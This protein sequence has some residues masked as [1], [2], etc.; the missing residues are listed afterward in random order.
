VL[1][2]P[3]SARVPQRIPG[4]AEAEIEMLLRE[5]VKLGGQASR[6][7]SDT[8]KDALAGLVRA[9]KIRKAAVWQ[10]PDLQAFGVAEILAGL[11]V[12]IV[13]AQAGNDALAQCDLGVTGAD[14][15]LPETGTLVLR[16]APD[17][18]RA[19]SLLPRVH[20][21]LVRP[22]NLCA[23]LAVA[24]HEL[25][26]DPYFVFVTGPSRTAD[27]EMTVTVGVHGPQVLAVWAIN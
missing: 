3:A 5:I 21:A 2:V 13:P 22:E 4:R 10:T 14:R 23:D 24:L 25:C 12:E 9:E 15:A 18:P 17:R 7:S 26:S 6:V 1:P 19:V 16:A 8:L 11:N 20:L 27:I